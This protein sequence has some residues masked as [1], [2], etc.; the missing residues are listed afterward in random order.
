MQFREFFG[1][2]RDID[3]KHKKGTKFAQQSKKRASPKKFAML[4]KKRVLQE[5]KR[6]FLTHLVFCVQIKI[7]GKISYTADILYKSQKPSKN[8]ASGGIF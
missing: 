1:R 7:C 8:L 2:L 5:T 4:I 3:Q 6:I